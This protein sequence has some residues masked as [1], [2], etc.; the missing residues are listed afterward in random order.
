MKNY[1]RYEFFSLHPSAI[2]ASPGFCFVS[3][4]RILWIYSAILRTSPAHDAFGTRRKSFCRTHCPSSGFLKEPSRRQGRFSSG[5]HS[6]A[7]CFYSICHI[8]PVF[9]ES[10]A[11]SYRLGIKLF[12]CTCSSSPLIASAALS[13]AFFVPCQLQRSEHQRLAIRLCVFPCSLQH[14]QEH[15]WRSR[16]LVWSMKSTHTLSEGAL[17][18]KD[19]PETERPWWGMSFPETTWKGT[20]QGISMRE[21]RRR[22]PWTG[23]T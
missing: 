7:R 20:F 12:A 13:S 5:N 16:E 19:I 4:S 23:S 8:S 9:S 10:H 11:R 17:Q 21:T 18:I 3:I 2:A 1:L 14:P 15:A 22:A 6:L